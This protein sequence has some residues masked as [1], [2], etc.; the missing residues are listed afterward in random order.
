MT[1]ECN[2]IKLVSVTKVGKLSN[3][4]LTAVTKVCQHPWSER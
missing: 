4:K 2:E 1:K 3:I